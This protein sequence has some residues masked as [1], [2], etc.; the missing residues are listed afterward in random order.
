MTAGPGRPG[1][2]GKGLPGVPKPA[3]WRARI[4]TGVRE[5]H[6]RKRAERLERLARAEADA[7]R[8]VRTPAAEVYREHP[9]SKNRCPTCRRPFTAEGQP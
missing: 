1:R 2:P 8:L 3:A 4:A 6:A 7:G 9:L 5:A